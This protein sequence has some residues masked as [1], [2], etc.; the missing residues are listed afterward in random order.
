MGAAGSESGDQGPSLW[1]EQGRPR[2]LKAASQQRPKVCLLPFPLLFR[3]PRIKLR[4][5]RLGPWKLI[6][7]GLRVL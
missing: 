4:S 1:Q 5:S 6:L 2:C 7:Q 3:N